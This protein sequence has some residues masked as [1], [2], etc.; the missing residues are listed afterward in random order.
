MIGLDQCEGF[1]FG[2]APLKKTTS[3]FFTS[4]DMPL[5]NCYGLTETAGCAVL[6]NDSKF[7]LNSSGF[8]MPGT[9]VKIG[10]PD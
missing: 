9:E 10:N 2:A 1:Y 7:H 8:G 3:D 4:L 6:H 5:Y